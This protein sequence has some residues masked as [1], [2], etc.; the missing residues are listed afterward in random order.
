MGNGDILSASWLRGG[1]MTDSQTDGSGI[2]GQQGLNDGSSEYNQLEA[3]IA[4][5][6]GRIG[7]VKIVK[8]LAVKNNG[9]VEPV[10]LVDIQPLVNLMDGLGK[11]T[12]HGTIN[13]VPYMRLQGGKN[14]VIIDPVVGD[15]GYAVICDR[16]SSAVKNTK[17]QSNPGS[18]RRFS[19][20]DSIY[21][22]GIL[23]AAPEQ[24][25]TFTDTGI[26]IADKNNN[27]I[28]MKS[29][30]LKLTDANSNIVEMKAGGVFVTGNLVVNGNLQMSGQI[31][32][33][34]GTLYPGNMHIGG[35]MTADTDVIAAGKSGASHTHNAPGGATGP[36]L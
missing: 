25:I 11:S 35:T 6:M 7:T 14:A 22:G 8:V 19:L 34:T 17:K 16:D 24:Y 21:V 2:A 31:Q 23:N 12:P 13:N 10:G 9:G 18:F 5:A 27:V 26:K 15:I 20:A 33:L 28:E 32:S 29:G 30:S 3:A 1:R 4:T 36:P